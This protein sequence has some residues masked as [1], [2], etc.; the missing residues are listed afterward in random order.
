MF[1]ASVAYL[2]AVIIQPLSTYGRDQSVISGR[3]S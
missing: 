1:V 2:K 3:E